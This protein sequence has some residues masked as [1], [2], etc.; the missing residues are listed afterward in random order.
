[1][2]IMKDIFISMQEAYR[3]GA[4]IERETARRLVARERQ[5]TL[6]KT[7]KEYSSQ[8]YKAKT[9]KELDNNNTKDT[10]DEQ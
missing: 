3:V 4:D 1:M 10:T 7:M 5:I 2:S 8:R 6:L 9:M